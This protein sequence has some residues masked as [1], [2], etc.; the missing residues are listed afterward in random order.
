MPRP[1]EDLRKSDLTRAAIVDA[2][3]EFLWSHPFRDLT[4][5]RLMALTGVSRSA[6]YHYFR[7]V[8]ELLETQLSELGAQIL[9]EADAWFTGSGDVRALLRESLAGMVR[10]TYASG[11]IVRAVTDAAPNDKRLEQ[12][13][14]RF[15]RGFDAAVAERI[16]ADQKLG[17]IADMD[18]RQMAVVLNRMDAYTFIHAFGRHPRENPD[19]VL[20][21][22][23]RIW[24]ATLFE[25]PL[26]TG[27][28]PLIRKPK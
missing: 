7:D 20:A 26:T 8:H 3:L 5:N 24:L 28:A 19:R 25:T 23:E 16:E 15:M 13:W 21:T 2:A 10:V 17:L 14:Q 9:S 12:A 11:P 18:A 4:V 6:F 27:T 1:T 22:I